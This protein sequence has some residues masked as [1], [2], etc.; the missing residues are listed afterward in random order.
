MG[1][2]KNLLLL[3]FFGHKNL[4]DDLLLLQALQKIPAEYALF[5]IW[6]RNATAEASKFLTIRHFTPVYDW[7]EALRTRYAALIYSGGGLFPSLSFGW[8]QLL[9]HVELSLTSK[10]R[11]LNGVGIVPKTK[12]FW[13][14]LFLR[15]FDYVSVRD[16]LSQTFVSKIYPDV[17]NCGDLYWG[18][19]YNSLKDNKLKIAGGGVKRP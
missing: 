3:G 4:G 8:R 2:N 15:T 7:K 18:A 13:F 10:K 17:I 12:R 9:R 6:P 16:E 1:K 14:D 11:I 19:S 5:I